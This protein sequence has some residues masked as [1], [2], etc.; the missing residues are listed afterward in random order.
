M[1]FTL[2][3]LNALIPERWVL[4]ALD[5]DGSGDAEAFADVQAAAVK[6]VNAPLS[7]RYATPVE[8]TEFICRTALL[9]AAEACYKRRQM[10]DQFPYDE[11]LKD[12]RKLLVEMAKGGLT[13]TPDTKPKNATGGFVGE[14]SK[15]SPRNSV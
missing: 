7:I 3:D 5:D 9:I 2:A 13:P 11:E 8:G 15:L 1:Y 14:P 12:A 10:G 6:A 4:E